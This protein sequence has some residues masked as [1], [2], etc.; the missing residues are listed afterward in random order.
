MEENTCPKCGA[1]TTKEIL[2]DKHDI[3]T[4]YEWYTTSKDCAGK[5]NIMDVLLEEYFNDYKKFIERSRKN[6][7]NSN[8]KA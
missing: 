2:P 5:P 4:F 1:I 8:R 6:E 3:F 7:A